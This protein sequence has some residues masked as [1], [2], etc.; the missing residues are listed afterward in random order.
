MHRSASTNECPCCYC[1]SLYCPQVSC[2]YTLH[3]YICTHQMPFNV[4]APLST[5][6]GYLLSHGQHL[7]NAWYIGP[8]NTASKLFRSTLVSTPD[9]YPCRKMGK[10][11]S[12][13]TGMPN[14]QHSLFHGQHQGIHSVHRDSN[15][16]KRTVLQLY[17]VVKSWSAPGEVLGT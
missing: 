3:T 16:Y 17:L 7:G 8:G 9:I 15:S 5:Y 12:S 1:Q 4:S 14:I 6:N 10:E 13:K 11:R 2:T